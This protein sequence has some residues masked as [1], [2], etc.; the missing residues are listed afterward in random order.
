MA[1]ASKFADF[2][3]IPLAQTAISSKML[4]VGV[5]VDPVDNYDEDTKVHSEKLNDK[6]EHQWNLRVFAKP[7]VGDTETLADIINVKIWAKARPVIKEDAPIIF[8][9]FA[10]RPWVTSKHGKVNSG[11][12]FSASGFRQ[13]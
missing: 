3:R 12:S 11:L 9:D 5:D 1:F 2:R 8:T 10:M 13:E 6:G 4:A 7:L